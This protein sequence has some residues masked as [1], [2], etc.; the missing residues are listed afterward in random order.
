MQISST[1][2]WAGNSDGYKIALMSWASY[3]YR[4]LGRAKK[5]KLSNTTRSLTT[6]K[7]IAHAS[8]KLF[9]ITCYW[10]PIYYGELDLVL[11]RPVKNNNQFK[12]LSF[13]KGFLNGWR[14]SLG[15]F[16]LLWLLRN[17]LAV[18]RVVLSKKYTLRKHNV[19]QKLC[20][21]KNVSWQL[22]QSVWNRKVSYKERTYTAN[23]IF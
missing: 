15:K 14:A 3:Y 18:M 19:F 16:A 11:R 21:Y 17:V 6:A 13:H 10:L 2:A 5:R 7:L 1:V 22:L 20:S 8:N 4:I 9:A 12:E 23:F